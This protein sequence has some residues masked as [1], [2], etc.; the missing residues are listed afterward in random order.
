MK[1]LHIIVMAAGNSTRLKSPRSKILHSICGRPMIDYVLDAAQALRPKETLLVLGNDR[2]KVKDHLKGRRGLKFV[3][4]KER[5]GTAHA[6]QTALGRLKKASRGTI[7]ILSGDVPMLRPQ[8]LRTLLK[9]Q[10]GQG[11][12][13]LTAIHPNPYGYG[14]IL[15]DREG[16]VYGVIEEKNAGPE[17]RVLN[18]INAGVYAADLKFLKSALRSVKPD[19]LKREY[20]L[21]DIVGLAA[22][23]G[24]RLR[25]LNLRDA[26]EV[27]G[28]N[29]RAEL[30]YL[31]QLMRQEILGR[32]LENGVG[33]EDPETVFVDHGVRIGE[34]T[35]I[36][37]GVHLSG[38]TRVGRGC[39]LETGSYLKDAELG[40]GVHLKAYSYLEECVVRPRAVIGPFARLRPGTVLEREVHIGNFVELKKTRM[41]RGS[42][43]NLLCYLGDATVGA[44]VNIGAGTITCNYDGRKKYPTFIGDGVFIGSDTQLVEPVRVGRAA[45]VA[46]GT[47]VTKDVPPGALAISRV[48]QKN[49]P[50]YVRKKVARR[51]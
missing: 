22:Q 30:A 14:R 39:R 8:T 24:V 10:G 16:R 37:A 46:A 4:Q 11:L 36:E 50:R 25:A 45:Y 1:A 19:P 21:T 7:L 32:H 43:A 29:N 13:L 23:Q 6:V 44:R 34:D 47:T 5:R 3:H 26:H 28:V 27:L 9:A 17:Q 20:Y 18:E 42:K 51:S 38:Q 49:V 15:R 35:F 48:S 33:L 40:E 31:N 2:E 41:G 12:A